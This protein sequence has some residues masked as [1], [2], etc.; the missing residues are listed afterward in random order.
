MARGKFG[1][2]IRNSAT[3]LGEMRPCC[4]Q[5]ISRALADFNS[6]DHWMISNGVPT[7][8]TVGSS[9]KYF[10]SRM[11]DVLS[12]RSRRRPSLAK[13]QPSPCDIVAS[14]IP[15]K[16]WLFALTSARNAWRFWLVRPRDTPSLTTK[17]KRLTCSHMSVEMISRTD[18]AFSRAATRQDK[19]ELG[20]AASA[21]RNWITA[22]F[23][24]LPYRFEKA[25]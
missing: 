19:I 10:T 21:E 11:R 15:R 3:V 9:M 12:A 7:S 2:R 8:A 25:S 23:V 5:Y 14:V 18:R 20:F 6:A 22:S 24:A 1:L 13:C 17:W 4:L 16:R